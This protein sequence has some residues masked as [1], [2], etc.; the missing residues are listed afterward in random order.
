MKYSEASF[1]LSPYSEAAGDVLAA[2]LAEIGFDTFVPAADGLKAYVQTSVLDADAVA[3]LAANFP[4]PDVA[5]S[6]SIKA[7]PDEN[8]NATWEQQHTF[9]PIDLPGGKRLTVVPRQAFGSGE[10]ATTRMM[11]K[12]L[13]GL[14]LQGT[15]VIDAGCGTGILG[16]AALLLGADHLVAYDI[17]EWSVANA[18]DNLRLNEIDPACAEIREGDSSVLT[19]ADMADVLLANIN[20]N[21][22]LADMPT[23][24][25]HTRIGGHVLLSGF[26]EDDVAL[27]RASAEAL[28]LDFVGSEADGEWRALHFLKSR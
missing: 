24:A 26:Y 8:W 28:G 25:A 18:L 21:I 11:V 5:V 23:F 9:E 10:H 16:F 17:D 13:C 3:S 27:L 4:F 7:A 12:L 1:L 14:D 6:Y 22:L 20:R 19:A 2:L 15:T